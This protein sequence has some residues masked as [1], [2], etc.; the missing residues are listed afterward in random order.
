MDGSYRFEGVTA[1]TASEDGDH[2]MIEVGS[3]DGPQTISL[4]TEDV[5]RVVHLLLQ[6]AGKADEI[7]G[8]P[9]HRITDLH[10]LEIATAPSAPEYAILL[11]RLRPGDPQ[12]AYRMHKQSL[13]EIALGLLQSMGALP[14]DRPPGVLQ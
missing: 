7:R 4:P 10:D 14:S 2:V 13:A 6:A 5:A 8:V 3:A 11:V 1:A 12:V 9:R